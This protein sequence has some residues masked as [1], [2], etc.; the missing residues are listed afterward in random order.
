LCALRAASRVRACRTA[1][2]AVVAA[3]AA[4]LLVT[5]PSARLGAS[6]GSTLFVQAFNNNTVNSGYPVSLPA[7]PTSVTGG[8]AACL[9]A[10]GNTA[11]GPLLSCPS[12]NDTQGSGKM[13][14]TSTG[15]FQEGGA[16][17]AASVPTSEGIDATF[18]TYQYG[19]NNADGIAFVLAAVKPRRP[20]VAGEPRAARR[21]AGL[22]GQVAV[23]QSRHGLRLHGRRPGRL[24][25]LQ[26]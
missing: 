3:A 2:L 25:Q 15:T 24:W 11:T 12:N 5:V 13:R 23:Q 20:A 22:L 26:Q 8:N 21:C 19:G 18:N 17:S 10:S 16:F 7:V 4:G 1:Q 9:T 6:S 14:L